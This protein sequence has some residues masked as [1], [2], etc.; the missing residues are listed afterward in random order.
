ME[1]TRE[2][3]DEI[4]E[5]TPVG[6]PVASEEATDSAEEIAE[7][8]SVVALPKADVASPAIEVATE[9]IELASELRSD[10]ATAPAAKAKTTGFEKCIV[11][12]GVGK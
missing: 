4:N 2:S 10:C 12:L 8:A 11:N 3:A 9:A 7:L 6:T 1:E 5:L